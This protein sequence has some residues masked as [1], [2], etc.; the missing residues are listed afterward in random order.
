MVAILF[1]LRKETW[2]T[3]KLQVLITAHPLLIYN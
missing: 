3:W 1:K 2:I